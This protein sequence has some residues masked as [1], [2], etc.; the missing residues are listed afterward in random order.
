MGTGEKKR[1]F[2]LGY[3]GAGKT[4]IG[5]MLAKKLKWSFLDVDKFIENRYHQTIAAIFEEKGEAG[6]REIEYRTLNE[7]CNFENVVISTGGGLPCFFDNMNLMNQNGI[8]VYLKT[9]INDLICRLNFNKQ[10]RPLI[11]GKNLEELRDFVEMNLKKR[12]PFYNQA[13][14]IIDNQHFSTKEEL[15]QWVEENIFPEVSL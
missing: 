13:Q 9:Q 14:I 7:I 4:T 12:E 8:T 6:F 2:L 1:L 11:K 15:N 5:K 3:M 10:K